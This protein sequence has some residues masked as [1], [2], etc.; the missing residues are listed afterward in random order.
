MVLIVGQNSVWQNTYKLPSLVEGSVNRIASVFASAAGKGSNVARALAFLRRDSL[1]LA[2]IGGPNGRKF[3]AACDADGI[4]SDFTEI[5]RETRICTTLIEDSGRITEVVEPAPA[6]SPEE[7]RSF[8]STFDR[9]ISDA[10]MLVISGTAM[11]GESDDCYLDFVRAAHNAGVAVVL[12]SYRDHGKRALEASPE[13]LKINSDEV[14][15]LSGTD[16]TTRGG[17]QSASELIMSRYGVRW[18]IIT[19]GGAGAEAYDKATAFSGEAPEVVL[20]NAIGSGDS[21]TAGIV[22]TLLREVRGAERT[23]RADFPWGADLATALKVGIAMGSANCMNIKPAHI[24]PE[25]FQ[26]VSKRI[27]IT[28]IAP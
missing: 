28:Q 26:S 5:S 17:R 7:V 22:D 15:E 14:A 21:F 23:D 11:T 3:R 18:I 12:D 27:G 19:R 2:Y 8:R 1:L 25:D 16:C 13:V 10:S 20:K 9:H 6:V 24:E 4:R